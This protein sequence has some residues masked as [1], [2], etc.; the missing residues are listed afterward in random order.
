M[1]VSAPE[2]PARRL[3]M[4]IISID[5]FA[6]ALASV[7]SRKPLSI[8]SAKV[9]SSVWKAVWDMG[10]ASAPF[11]AYI[12]AVVIIIRCAYSTTGFVARAKSS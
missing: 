6:R 1:N 2:H 5:C 9:G 12:G 11:A 7:M 3:K 8:M 10:M 4:Q